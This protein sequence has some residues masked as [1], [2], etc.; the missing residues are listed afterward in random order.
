MT[1]GGPSQPSQPS[2]TRYPT[3]R[4]H[5]LTR[6][7]PEADGETVA[8]S[9]TPSALVEATQGG[10]GHQSYTVGDI[11]VADTLTSLKRRKLEDGELLIGSTGAEPVATTLTG[12]TGITVTSA[13]GAVTIDSTPFT[14]DGNRA[15]VSDASGT[16]TGAPAMTDGQVLVGSTGSVPTPASITA[17]AN[18]SVTNAPGSITI[19]N[20]DPGITVDG[21]RALV[22]DGT[23]SVSAAPAMTDG[24]LLVGS[25]GSVP[26]PASITAGTGISVTNAP[27]SITISQNLLQVTK[28]SVDTDSTLS[29]TTPSYV[30][31]PGMSLTLTLEGEYLVLFD[32]VVSVTKDDATLSVAFYL[33][34]EEIA[35][36]ERNVFFN[37]W[38]E[39]EEHL[40]TMVYVTGV[41]A[42]ST[43][44]VQWKEDGH[45][46]NIAS[47]GTRALIAIRLVP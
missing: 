25:T 12:G 36:S 37:K 40:G 4:Y 7:I 28:T 17:G 2:V 41:T 33:N 47:V 18:I 1:I 44:L 13:P 11:L 14:V 35:N 20:T 16:V 21:N 24:Q 29:Q 30:P 26:T 46:D 15:L 22:S 3:F 8:G 34:G 43:F 5:Y 9:L 10:T 27:G 19:S 6:E 38:K 45:A 23:G 42:N 32:S 39:N 31:M